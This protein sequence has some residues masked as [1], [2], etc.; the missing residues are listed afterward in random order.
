MAE[1]AR[2]RKAAAR[3]QTR[4][5]AAAAADVILK[6]EEAEGQR[7]W[8]RWK[9]RKIEQVEE[10]GAKAVVAE[11]DH[12]VVEAVLASREVEAAGQHQVVEEAAPL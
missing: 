11:E 10:E 9:E 7:R 6:V 3:G 12:P 4:G 5:K 1:A 8:W 2:R